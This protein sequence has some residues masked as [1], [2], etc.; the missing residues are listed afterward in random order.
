MKKK[1]LFMIQIIY[2]IVSSHS[3]NA[4][5]ADFKRIIKDYLS[6]QTI[7]ASITQH[8]Y[9]QNGTTEF[10]SG[11][12]FAAAKGYVRIDYITPE[13]QVIV[14]NDTGLYWHYCD[15]GLVFVSEKNKEG[16]RPIPIFTASIP[17]ERLNNLEILFLGIKLY[18]FFKREEV[19]AVYSKTN[20][21]KLILWIDSS[22]GLIIR[23]YILDNSGREIIK[24]N[25][26]GHVN[27]KGIYIP[28][29]IE[30]KARTA[31]GII[32][33]VTEYSNMVINSPVD[34]ELFRFRIT[35]DLKVRVLSDKK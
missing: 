21:V 11:N 1:L 30:F 26:T 33:T 23:K 8:V 22:S 10:Y 32:Q 4:E 18:S 27:I 16:M 28:S 17:D 34:M 24:E 6:V 29:R 20:E 5:A 12:Y 31:D 13:K 7:K 2:V 35:P 19:Y 15:R 9:L 25:Y 14:I 3:F